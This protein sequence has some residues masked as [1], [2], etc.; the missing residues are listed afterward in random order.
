MRLDDVA[1]D[2]G[3][4]TVDHHLGDTDDEAAARQQ[5][6]RGRITEDC[7]DE[8]DE[9]DRANELGDHRDPS[10]I[11]PVDEYPSGQPHDEE[12]QEPGRGDGGHQAGIVGEVHGEKRERDE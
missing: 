10:A 12:R 2:S 4:S 3:K 6:N 7:H 1:Y 8:A 9:H 11:E 5:S